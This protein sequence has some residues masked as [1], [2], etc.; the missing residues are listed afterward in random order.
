MNNTINDKAQNLQFT[1]SKEK[2][3]AF[4]ILAL[5][6]LKELTLKTNS[7]DP[8]RFSRLYLCI[9]SL[10]KLNVS[11][12][13]EVFFVGLIGMQIIFHFVFLIFNL[14]F[15]LLGNIK[16]DN[17]IPCILKIN[18]NNENSS[19]NLSSTCATS[20]IE[21][22]IVDN[23]GKL[24]KQKQDQHKRQ[25]KS[26][27]EANAVDVSSTPINEVTSLSVSLGGSGSGIHK[28]VNSP[29]TTVTHVAK[30][31]ASNVATSSTL[32]QSS[33]SSSANLKL[34]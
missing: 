9:L 12:I 30:T 4:Q 26:E 7:V 14:L 11:I 8:E 3:H 5:K 31:G 23:E 2:I 29:M 1:L 17:I 15:Q 25:N 24:Q 28:I 22:I 34:V 19:K 6:E 27:D 21:T 33:F 16:I 20:S 10:K 32:F 13:E 18:S